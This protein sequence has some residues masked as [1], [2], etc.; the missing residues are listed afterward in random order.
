[1]TQ[2]PNTD[3]SPHYVDRNGTRIKFNTRGIT[4]DEHF[5]IDRQEIYIDA[6]CTIFILNPKRYQRHL[7]NVKITKV[8]ERTI[9]TN[10]GQ[11]IELDEIS[12]NIAYKHE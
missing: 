12:G 2:I 8:V 3:T 9:H 4:S 6:P 10:N 5:Y 1:M 7:R 11:S